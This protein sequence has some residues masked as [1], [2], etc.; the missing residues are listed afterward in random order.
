[1]S[2]DFFNRRAATWDASSST[3]DDRGIEELVARFG[4]SPGLTVLDAGAGTGAIV[5]HLRKTVGA[6]GRVIALDAA[7][8]MLA[9]AQPKLNE[10]AAG[11]LCADMSA[12]P[13]DDGSV[14]AV[15]CYSSFPH[16]GDKPRA[17]GEM[18]RVTG[19]G[20]R[21]FI[22]HSSSRMAINHRHHHMTEV[23]HDMIPDSERML[24]ML[25]AAGFTDVHIEDGADSY[26]ACARKPTREDE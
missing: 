3:G 19:H 26:L 6:G 11:Y 22:A 10:A 1:M 24:E 20:G 21:L 13:L 7:F 25:T 14:D 5:P 15:V 8:E 16:F 12:L 4:L 2:R 17:L 18:F 9:T 23:R